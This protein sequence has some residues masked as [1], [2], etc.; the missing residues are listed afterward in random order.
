MP[1]DLV[2]SL[3]RVLGSEHVL[4]D[5]DLRAGYEMDW[6]GR[7]DATGFA[8]AVVRPA[9][10]A[11]VASVLA[12]CDAAGAAVVTQGGNTGLVGG[13]VPRRGLTRPQVVLST[14]RLRAIGAV[15]EASA[16]LTCGAG[17]LLVDAQDAARD[18]GFE[19]GID[20]GARAS[21]TI[22]GMVATNAGGVHVLANGPMASQ[23][24]RAEAV[25]ADGSVVG[26]ATGPIKDNSGYRWG[27]ILCGTEG[28]LAVVTAVQLRL[29]A[30][31]PESSRR[32]AVYG[33][34][35]FASATDLCGRARK[36]ASVRAVEAFDAA[37][38]ALVC[39]HLALPA[40][41][42]RPCDV[43]VLVEGDE[44]D[45]AL[46]A[47]A[48][49]VRDTAVGTDA[50][51]TAR[52]WRYREA[53]PEAIAAHGTPHKLDVALPAAAVAE[54]AAA[55]AGVAPDVVLFGHLGDGNLHVNLLGLSPADDAVDSGVYELTARLGGS[56]SAEHGIGVAKA[57][58]LHLARGADDIAAM[59]RVKAALDPRATLNPGVILAGYAASA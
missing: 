33:V 49:Y 11:E 50:E 20:L 48:P 59:V 44:A 32:A 15:D 52:L 9:S 28:T 38:L 54:F 55:V 18:A 25:L 36:L 2:D 1:R 41:L 29:L 58:H 53:V 16:T 7:W 46:L 10:T 45:L 57:A 4:V 47:A 31:A 12:A 6:T 8:A 3:R 22:G 5:T 42:Q 27:A 43:H 35:D 14:Q 39:A 26:K 56:I 30:P 37:A 21:A 23:V 24:V 34:D 13:S 40:P 19:L 51:A 17:T